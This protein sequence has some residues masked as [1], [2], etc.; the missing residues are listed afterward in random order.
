M[1]PGT[2]IGIV[3]AIVLGGP[4]LFAIGW[5]LFKKD[6]GEQY[7]SA[8]LIWL[9]TKQIFTFNKE[10]REALKDE[11]WVKGNKEKQILEV[12]EMTE[13]LVEWEDDEVTAMVLKNQKKT[14]KVK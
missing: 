10:K 12:H 4:T 3:S 13:D 2:I 5:V 1:Y 6:E 7:T 8:Y 14:K 9:R 11:I